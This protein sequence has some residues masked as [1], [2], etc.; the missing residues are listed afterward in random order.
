V[1]VSRAGR[2]VITVMRDDGPNLRRLVGLPAEGT[3]AIL[4]YRPLRTSFLIR[5]LIQIPPSREVKFS[6]FAAER[7][8]LIVFSSYRTRQKHGRI[9]WSARV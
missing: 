7:M 3:D 8:S 6:F 9:A 4:K 5:G 1:D 2:V